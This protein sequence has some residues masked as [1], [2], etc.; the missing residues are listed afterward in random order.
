MQDHITETPDGRPLAVEEFP[1]HLPPSEKV[2]PDMAEFELPPT[3]AEVEHVEAAPTDQSSAK[4]EPS[5]PGQN[6]QRAL[7]AARAR[8]ADLIAKRPQLQNAQ[9]VARAAVAE[10]V[11]AYQEC[12]PHRQT[13]AELSAEFRRASN[14]QRAARARGE[15]W[16][17]PPEQKPKGQRAFVDLER[18]YSSGGDGNQFARS[19]NR[20]GNRRGAYGKH[21]LGTINR[22][23]SRGP[24]PA[25]VTTRPT[26]PALAK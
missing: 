3:I 11:R 16:A 4:H 14:E 6:P 19:Q 12:D 20:T 22:D 15:A 18:A 10:A 23:P 1:T 26:I 21:A 25:P 17:C 2:A 8:E 9:K 13:P 5:A 7:D 24:V